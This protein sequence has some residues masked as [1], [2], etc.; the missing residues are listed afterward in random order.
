M[1]RAADAKDVDKLFSVGSDL[2]EACVYCHERYVDASTDA[3][4]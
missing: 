4:R 2:Y 3:N 1:W